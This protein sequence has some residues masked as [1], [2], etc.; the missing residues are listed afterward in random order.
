MCLIEVLD[1]KVKSRKNS[2]IYS[3]QKLPKFNGR[4]IFTTSKNLVY[5]KKDE[6][7][8]ANLYTFTE[9]DTIYTEPDQN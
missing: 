6:W 7:K 5:P 2:Q 9:P 1:K 3:G 4:H 8:E